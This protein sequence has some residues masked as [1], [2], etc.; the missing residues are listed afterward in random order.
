VAAERHEFARREKRLLQSISSL[1]SDLRNVILERDDQAREC[2]A[3]LHALQE[4]HASSAWRLV[5]FSRHAIVGLLPAGTR[6]R[7]A[8][9]AVLRRIARRA[10]V[11]PRTA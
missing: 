5:T 2:E 11:D 9:N 4:I 7:R 10:D 6:R 3:A 8:F 1:E